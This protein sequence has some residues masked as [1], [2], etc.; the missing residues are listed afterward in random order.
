MRT[1]IDHTDVNRLGADAEGRGSVSIVVPTFN[2]L[3]YLR[4]ALRATARVCMPIDP[5]RWRRSSEPG[6]A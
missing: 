5:H 3:D 4:L 1:N 2:R 6:T